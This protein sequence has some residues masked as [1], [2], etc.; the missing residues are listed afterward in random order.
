MRIYSWNVNG[1]RAVN[2]K[3]FL[4]WIEEEKPDVLALQEIRIQPEQLKDKLKNIDGYHSYF[5]YGEKAGYSG[6]AIYSKE[7]PLDVWKG[8]GIER[9]DYEGRVIAAEYPE[10]YLLNIYFPNG[11]SSK[12]RLNY[13]LDFYD[14]TLEYAEELRE[15][16]KGVVVSGDYNTA[17]HP[18]DLKNPDANKNTSGFLEIEREWL[19]KLE[20]HG[21]IDTYRYFYPDKETY[22]WWSYRTRARERNAGWRI[23]YHFISEELEDNLNH[24][25]ILTDVMGSDH[26]PV[27]VDLKF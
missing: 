1:I 5:N 3:G 6:V 14:A 23:D 25:D 11:K 26:C 21:F 10:F 2:R 15:E 4:D 8:F 20:N 13:K 24:S 7:E 27:T 12:E 22:S 16:G 17:H 9:F 18:L 19:D